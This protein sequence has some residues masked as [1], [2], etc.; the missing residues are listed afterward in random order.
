MERFLAEIRQA[1][2]DLFQSGLNSIQEETFGNLKR[3]AKESGT[4]GL[5]GAEEA[6]TF[7][8]EALGGKRHQMEFDMEA[9]LKTWIHLMTYV[10]LCREK[11]SLDRALLEMQETD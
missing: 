5:H 4:L 10:K 3:L 9:V 7:L 8:A 11:T 1:L 2:G 6:L